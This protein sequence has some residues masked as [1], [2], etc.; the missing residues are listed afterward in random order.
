[1]TSPGPG[2]PSASPEATGTRSAR[3]A[4]LDGL[5]GLVIISVVINHASGRLWPR[6]EAYETPVVAGLLSGG[7]VVVFFVVG[8]FIVT[9]SLQRDIGR[10]RLDPVRFFVRRLVR[11]WPQLVLLCAALVALNSLTELHRRSTD[12]QMTTNV[13]ETLSFTFNIWGASDPLAVRPELGHLWYLS[14]QQQCYLVLPLVLLLF[15]RRRA[16]FC[17]GALALIGAV[18]VHRVQVLDQDGWVVASTLTSTRADGLIWGVLLAVLLPTLGRMRRWDRVLW[19]SAAALLALKLVL[20]EL[21]PFAYLGWWSLAFTGVAGIVTLA[22]WKLEAPTRVSRLLALSPLARLGKSSYAI[23]VW[24]LPIIL[25][26]ERH[27]PDLTWP[28]RSLLALAVL[29]V[30][31]VLAE[32]FVEGPVRRRLARMPSSAAPASITAGAQA[33]TGTR[34]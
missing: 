2:D 15:S 9:T 31:V 6:G 20:P 25:V 33:T 8:A 23:F 1:M 10:D 3:N 30:V 12:L 13:V 16:L 5:R 4:A 27:A 22:V 28:L 17:A 21:G 26:V 24:H 11:L 7:A 14:V 32:V 19:V 18:F 34:R 29:T